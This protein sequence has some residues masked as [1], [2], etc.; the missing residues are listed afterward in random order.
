[1]VDIFRNSEAAGQITD[2]A[3]KAVQNR[4]DAAWRS[5]RRSGETRRRRG[6][7]RRHEPL[8]EI[9]YARLYGELSDGI[10]SH[11]ITSKRRKRLKGGYEQ[12]QTRI[13]TLSVHAT[14]DPTTGARPIYEY[15][16]CL[17]RCRSRGSLFN[18][19]LPGFIYSRLTIRRSPPGGAY[20]ALETRGATA[21]SSGHAAQILAL[22]P[23][24]HRATRSSPPISSMAALS[25]RWGS[26]TKS[27]AG[28]PPSSI[29]TSRISAPHHR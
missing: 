6:S 21:T 29:R 9:E 12:S 5:Q 8:P 1:M 16:F 15:V 10:N 13:E 3:I 22:F 14:A 4:L 28:T 7:P 24:M 18:L 27:S 25:I 11:V 20:A 19:Q 26:A 17:R 23:L 2:D